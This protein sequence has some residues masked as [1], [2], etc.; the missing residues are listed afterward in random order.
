MTS[1]YERYRPQTWDQ[2][3]GQDKIVRQ[4]IDNDGAGEWL[5]SRCQDLQGRLWDVLWL[6]GLALRGSPNRPRVYS[7]SVIR[8][9]VKPR[10]RRTTG[11][12]IQIAACDDGSPCVVIMLPD[13]D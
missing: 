13:E 1:L 9:D 4:P 10:G 2:V 8:H 3:V 6:G 5:K 11:L 7:L 12:K